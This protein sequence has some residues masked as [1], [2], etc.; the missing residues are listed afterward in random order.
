MKIFFNND[1]F[2]IYILNTNNSTNLKEYV[3]KTVLKIK[4][5]TRK[6]ISGYYKVYV[7]INKTYGMV[8]EAIKKDDFDFFKDYI[9]LDI[10]IKENSEMY[11]KFSDYFIPLNKSN[12]YYY[13]DNYYIDIKDL[14]KKDFYK[15]LEHS[16]IIYGNSLALIQN[17][18]QKLKYI[19]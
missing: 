3:K 15:L 16:S 2:T 10:E 5:K 8:L 1:N 19:V 17:N 12:I 18:L 13:D 7:Y 4:D 11:F 14:T 6:Y 9:E